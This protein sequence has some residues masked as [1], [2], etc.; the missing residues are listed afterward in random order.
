MDCSGECG[1]SAVED[2]CGVCGGDG[3]SCN[4]G[5]QFDKIDDQSN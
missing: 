4:Y 2:D 5:V 3:S 1:G